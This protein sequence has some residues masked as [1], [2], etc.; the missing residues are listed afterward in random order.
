M[1]LILDNSYLEIVIAKSS[2]A[3]SAF[4]RVDNQLSDIERM[5]A[6]Y[7]AFDFIRFLS[8]FYSLFCTCGVARE[9]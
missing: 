9:S 1:E 3:S 5:T 4:D 6:D 7:V 2:S 8:R